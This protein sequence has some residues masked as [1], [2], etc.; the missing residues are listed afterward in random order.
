[1]GGWVGSKDGYRTL[2]SVEPYAFV[3]PYLLFAM[4]NAW[5]ERD[6]LRDINAIQCVVKGGNLR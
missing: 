1:M 4:D 6:P 3:L 2:L 5:P